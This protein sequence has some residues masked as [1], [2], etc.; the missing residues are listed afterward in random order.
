MAA[1][2]GSYHDSHLTLD[3]ARPLV[4]SV[5]A[6]HLSPFIPPDA[7]VLEIGAGYCDWIN[8]VR[9]ARRVAVDVWPEVR[10]FAGAGVDSQVLDVSTDLRTFPPGSFDTVLASNI[11]EHF[12]PDVT[13]EIVADV[14]AL[15]R[16]GGRLLIIQPNFAHAPRQYFDDYTHRS[17][18]THVSLPALLRSR[19]FLI[20]AVKPRFLPYSMRGS[21]LPIQ[22]WLVRAYLQSPFKPMAGQML[23]VARKP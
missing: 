18:F 1:V 4:W 12:V 22:R 21:R 7:E 6:E 10:R 2:T 17:V 13:A 19:G 3:P 14:F 5:V 20:D 9:A 23:V 16:P 8:Q 15:L 11:L